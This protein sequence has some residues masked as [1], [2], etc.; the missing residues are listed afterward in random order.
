ML[1]WYSFLVLFWISMCYIT[2]QS[3]VKEWR[4]L[5]QNFSSKHNELE[6]ENIVFRS[7]LFD[8]GLKTELVYLATKWEINF[9]SLL[10]YKNSCTTQRKNINK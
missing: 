10:L 4:L 8:K 9:C 1:L 2:L 3:F 6:H 7:F 5:R